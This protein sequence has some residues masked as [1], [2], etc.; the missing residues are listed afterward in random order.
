[1]GFRTHVFPGSRKARDIWNGAGDAGE[2]RIDLPAYEALAASGL[3]RCGLTQ[4]AG[5]TVGAPFVGAVAAAVGVAELLR[6]V[7][8]ANAYEV[9]DGHLRDLNYR[10]VVAAGN[11]PPINPGSTAA[12]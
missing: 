11:L 5:R 10:T 3:D 6:L 4:L 8:G 1:M 7:N 2:V 9:V 12:A